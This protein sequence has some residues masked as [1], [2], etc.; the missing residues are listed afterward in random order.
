MKY[1]AVYSYKKTD[2]K[3]LVL[4]ILTLQNIEEWNGAI[5]IVGDDP[6]C[7]LPAYYTHIPI[8]HNWGKE[9]NCRSNDEI[10]AY[11]TAAEIVGDFI[12]M[13]DD[14]FVLKPWS[15]A[16][17]NRGLIN[18]HIAS[19]NIRDS[20]ML[21]LKSTAKWLREHNKSEFSYEL[22]IPFLVEADKFL[23]I[24]SIIPRIKDGV[25]F[26]SVYGNWFG[27]PSTMAN[28]TK[29]KLITGE[30][31]IYSSSNKTFNYNEVNKHVRNTY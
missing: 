18:D 19:R 3:E 20:Y 21:Q 16:R 4:S 14:I 11:Q 7:F 29:N 23:E 25:L 30:T 12:A 10:C 31:V 22:H 5:Y 6:D 15:L 13:S 27:E 8:A 26:R 1:P 24:V 2:T 9:S 28:D 17:H